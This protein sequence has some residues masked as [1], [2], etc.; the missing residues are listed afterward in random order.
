MCYGSL[1]PKYAMREAEGRLKGVS[2]AAETKE[3]DA[4]LP[5][6]GLVAWLRAARARLKWKDELHV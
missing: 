3:S 1:D 2:F 5:A 4:A 6:F